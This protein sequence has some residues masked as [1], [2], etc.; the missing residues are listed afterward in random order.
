MSVLKP[1]AT[2]V[3][4]VP[5]A[6][7]PLEVMSALAQW[8]TLEMVICAPMSMSVP[9]QLHVINMLIATIQLVASFVLVRMDTAVME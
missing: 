5:T 1:I 3:V 2:T 6:P 9:M 8:A 7:T 4:L